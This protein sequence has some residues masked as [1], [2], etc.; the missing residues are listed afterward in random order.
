M[1][2]P[3]LHILD[4]QNFDYSRLEYYD[5]LQ[6]KGGSYVSN[7]NYLLDD[8]NSTP[9]YIQTPRLKVTSGVIET[10][11]KTYIELDLDSSDK[12]N[13]EFYNFVMKLDEINLR[14]C[15]R[16]SKSWFGQ[17]F[18]LDDI[19]KS[20]DGPIKA[21]RGRSPSIKL[22]LQTIRGNLITEIY[23]DRKQQTDVDYI[24]GGDYVVAIIEFDGLKFG[25]NRFIF[26]MSVSQIKVYKEETKGKITGY[27]IQDGNQVNFYPG[28]DDKDDYTSDVEEVPLSQ[29]DRQRYDTQYNDPDILSDVEHDVDHDVDEIQEPIIEPLQEPEPERESEPEPEQDQESEQESEPEPEQESEPEQEEDQDEESIKEISGEVNVKYSLDDNNYEIDDLIP[30]ELSTVNFGINNK[31]YIEQ[32]NDMRD[33]IRNLMNEFEIYKDEYQNNIKEYHT[34]IDE[35]RE[36]YRELCHRYNTI[37]EF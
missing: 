15:H 34:M 21:N 35:R 10:T 30:N 13:M 9:I 23:N 14:T 37:P 1:N 25:K 8:N 28:K 18:P 20:Y 33:N 11:R 19:D 12:S 26:D 29:D 24:N 16:K 5:P 17:Q 22:N 32:V 2:N 7:I 6:T 31:Q 4:Y 36:K 27:H 3:E